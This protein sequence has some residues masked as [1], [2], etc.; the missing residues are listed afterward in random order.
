MTAPA[1]TLRPATTGDYDFVYEVKKAALGS[2]IEAIW[3]W[4][5]DEQRGYHQR[6]FKPH[7]LEIVL[8]EGVPAGYFSVRR[9]PDA[10]HLNAI[11]LLP[12]FQGRGLGSALLQTLVDESKARHV[13]LRLQVFQAN[14]ARRWYERLGFT[15]T[16][17]TDTHFLMERPPP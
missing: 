13:P 6:E 12:A 5:E 2:Y 8:A 16:G 9:G 17:E 4:D 3:G 14:P 11:C 1:F 10:V 7:A 15:V